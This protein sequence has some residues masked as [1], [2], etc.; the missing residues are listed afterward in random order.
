[1]EHVRRI[2]FSFSRTPVNTVVIGEKLAIIE[3]HAARGSGVGVGNSV[4]ESFSGGRSCT[5]GQPTS[6]ISNETKQ[7][8]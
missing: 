7:T 3:F 2:M 6:L 5:A 1:M 4:A 8:S